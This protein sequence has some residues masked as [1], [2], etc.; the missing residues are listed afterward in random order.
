MKAII[1]P[2]VTGTYNLAASVDGLIYSEDGNPAGV[3]ECKTTKVKWDQ[4]PPQ[5]VSQVQWYLAITG[6]SFAI[7]S[8]YIIGD[9]AVEIRRLERDEE[10]IKIL[11]NNAKLLISHF[12]QEQEPQGWLRYSRKPEPAKPQQN[13]DQSQNDTNPVS[14]ILSE[15]PEGEVE[16]E[17]PEFDQLCDDA[18]KYRAIIKKYSELFANV[19]LQIAKK[20]RAA[21]ASALRTKRCEATIGYRKNVIYNIPDEVKSR[22][23]IVKPP[24]TYIRI[25][26]MKAE[27]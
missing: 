4:I 10:M 9:G 18:L 14:E 19:Q 2:E 1:A 6:L 11:L 20:M 16:F 7:L 17:D 24:I 23:A 5:Y 21:Q 13:S 15:C 27:K 22:Y 12:D 25:G 3:W 8:Y 26:R